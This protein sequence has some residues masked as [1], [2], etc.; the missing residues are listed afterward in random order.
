MVTMLAT[1]DGV[2]R[3]L[4]EL[5]KTNPQVV[6]LTADLAESTKVE[7][8]AKK[9]PQRFIEVGVAEQNM[10]GTAAGL[11]IGKKIPF[12]TSYGV[13]SPGLNWGVIRSAIAYSNL[14]VKII[15][16]H[17]GL[18]TGP[19][20]ATHQALEDIALMRA[21]PNMIVLAPADE[22]EAF[23]ATL[24]A[25][26]HSG[27]VYIRTSKLPVERVTTEKKPFEMGRAQVLKQGSDVTIIAHGTMVARAITASKLLEHIAISA[28]IINSPSIK[29]LDKTTILQAFRQ[30]QA[31][32]VV[33]DHQV[34]GG[35]GS[36]IAE[37][38]SQ[39]TI[40]APFKILGI[41]DSFGE[42]G[43]PDELYQKHELTA[44]HITEVVSGLF[45]SST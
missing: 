29:P 43:T 9:F 42:S 23:Q 2:G 45:H 39:E 20:G 8:F 37:L 16:G 36:A 7:E 32:V 14:P 17:S 41:Q 12:I 27:P 18:A 6:V 44:E 19:D 15:G 5:G 1:R 26:Q 4:L 22:E 24:A 31:V 10:A 3:A 34:A 13:F 33:E 40:R 30:T 11:A 21:L 38:L 35:L 25:A 28:R